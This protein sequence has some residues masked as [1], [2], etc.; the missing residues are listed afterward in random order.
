MHEESVLENSMC[1]DVAKDISAGQH[2]PPRK[3]VEGLEEALAKFRL[4]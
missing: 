3:E 1:S 2:L 4:G